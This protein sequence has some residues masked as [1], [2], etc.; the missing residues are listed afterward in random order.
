VVTAFEGEQ[1][2]GVEINGD[3]FFCGQDEGRDA[4]TRTVQQWVHWN[5]L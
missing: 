4:D 1:R 2:F 5:I 3:L